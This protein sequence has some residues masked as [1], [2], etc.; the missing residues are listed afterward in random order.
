LVDFPLFAFFVFVLRGVHMM[1][2]GTATGK[3]GFRGLILHVSNNGS[4]AFG[5]FDQWIVVATF[6]YFVTY[7]VFHTSG[8]GSSENSVR[9][10]GSCGE[11]C[12]DIQGAKISSNSL[13]L[14]GYAHCGDL[15]RH[16]RCWWR[17]MKLFLRF[18]VGY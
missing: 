7:L 11:F 15:H 12:I 4:C 1:Y 2:A 17:T 13:F 8:R 14:L 10:V 3:A 6:A 16:W 9:L 18:G 5:D